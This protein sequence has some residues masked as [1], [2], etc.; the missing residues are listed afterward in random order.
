MKLNKTFLIAQ[1]A[2]TTVD[3]IA[4]ANNLEDAITIKQGIRAWKEDDIYIF[5][6][7]QEG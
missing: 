3:V 6:E 5:E 7:V 1:M 2:G 4:V